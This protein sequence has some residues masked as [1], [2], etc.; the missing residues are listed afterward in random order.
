MKPRFSVKNFGISNSKMEGACGIKVRSPIVV[1][2]NVGE[3][4]KAT[5]GAVSM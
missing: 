2:G 1:P 3:P 4:Q 5:Q